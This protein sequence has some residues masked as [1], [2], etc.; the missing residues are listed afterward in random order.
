M[1][2]HQLVLFIQAPH[3]G[4]L[5]AA[6]LA[7]RV[8]SSKFGMKNSAEFR[9]LTGFRVSL[10]TKIHIV[11]IQLTQC[12]NNRHWFSFLVF[13]RLGDKMPY[14]TQKISIFFLTN[15]TTFLPTSVRCKVNISN[16]SKSSS[17]VL[18]PHPFSFPDAV[19]C[20]RSACR[21]YDECEWCDGDYSAYF[22]RFEH[23]QHVAFV[24]T[25]F[26]VS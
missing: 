23:L 22:P 11:C 21:W 20:I 2:C 16:I 13:T 6:V 3:V 9:V 19:S 17:K 1:Q 10:L 26:P 5:S 7:M 12:H 4:T 15:S 25:V 24:C 8:K 18:A 14:N